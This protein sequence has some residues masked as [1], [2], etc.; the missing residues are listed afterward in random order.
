MVRERMSHFIKLNLFLGCFLGFSI[1]FSA[2]THAQDSQGFYLGISAIKDTS[3]Y[4]FKRVETSPGLLFIDQDRFDWSGS[5]FGGELYIG[6]G[7]SL[8]SRFFWEEKAF[9]MLVPIPGISRLL[10]RILFIH[11]SSM[12]NSAS[13]GSMVLPF[14]QVSTSIS[15]LSS[16]VESA[17]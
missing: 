13:V 15:R 8:A 12:E 11:A 14:D 5:G 17:G 1:S 7:S 16:M 6:Y 2:A 3:S 4:D 10:I 9:I